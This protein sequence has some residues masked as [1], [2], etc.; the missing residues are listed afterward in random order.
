MNI[1]EN[2]FALR[3]AKRW[4]QAELAEKLGVSDQAVSKWECGQTAPDV[5]L[6]PILARLFGVSIDRLFGYEAHSY[7]T[8][9]REILGKVNECGSTR[10]E[11]DLL[12]DGL[13]RYPNSAPL[14]TTLAFSLLMLFRISEDEAERDS[15]AARAVG[16]CREVTQ[17]SGDPR[18]IDEANHMLCRI[19]TET[20]DYSRAKEAAERIGPERPLLRLMGIANVLYA[21]GN[22]AEFISFAADSLWESWHAAQFL[23]DFMTND[24][25]A[26]GELDRA[27][28][29]G[30]ARSRL[31]EVFDA[32]CPNFVTTAK[33]F[34]AERLA[35]IAKAAGDRAACLDALKRFD[36]LARQIPAVAASP[37]F[38]AA[39]RNPLFFGAA[40]DGGGEE[41]YMSE[42]R[43]DV[44]YRDF[45]GFFGD[46]EAWRTFRGGV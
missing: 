19:Y 38:H 5:S 10:A 25:M 31:L 34:A 4:T 2:I 3:R 36:A 7:D 1:G 24:A 28:G 11:I 15:A 32:G 41:E 6:F 14:K 17:T 21:S 18:E 37:D 22:R 26:A 42:V 13:A 27:R 23:L 40:T 44:L 20:G 9:V 16:L 46:G 12:T 43:P 29:F 35:R 39:A 33:L 45:D 8:E 30:E